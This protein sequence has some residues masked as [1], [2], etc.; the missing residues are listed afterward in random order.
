[1]PHPGIFNDGRNQGTH[2]GARCLVRFDVTRKVVCMLRSKYL[3][4]I[5]AAGVVSAV[6]AANVWS[7]RVQT[8]NHPEVGHFEIGY[9]EVEPVNGKG[10]SDISGPYS[11]VR[12]WPEPFEGGGIFGAVASV[13]AQS[14]DRVIVGARST[15]D[16]WPIRFN[17]EARAVFPHLSAQRN[18]RPEHILTV[19]DRNGKMIEHWKE[20]DGKIQ[21]IQRVRVS[22]YDPEGQVWIAGSGQLTQLTRDGKTLVRRVEAK[23]VP[24][25][26][27]QSTFFPE[28]M[29]FM[30]DGSFWVVSAERVIHFS[31][32]GEYLGE[33]GTLGKGPGELNGAHDIMFDP[34]GR[35]FYV[36]DRINHRIQV[37]DES[38][39]YVDQ[40]PNIVAPAVV[41]MTEDRRHVWVADIFTYKFLKYDLTGKL[42]TSWGTFGLGPGGILIGVHDFATDGEGNLYIADHGD[43]LQKLRPR[44][45]GN[46]EQL[47][48]KLL[49]M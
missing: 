6:V 30:K 44:K 13:F 10:G 47:I 9:E 3:Q 34:V 11:P 48:G 18:T 7:Q 38:G 45:D 4:A 16:P 8:T 29:A 24:T 14:P 22:P 15:K 1:M 20:W 49:P 40:W 28:G 41:R 19:F 35:R 21:S 17:W 43:R 46:P 5:L 2:S 36:A 33:F 23:D 39:R 42:V 12:N 37:F 27:D 31:K 26:P 25:K 32:S